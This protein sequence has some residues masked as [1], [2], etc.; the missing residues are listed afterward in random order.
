MKAYLGKNIYGLSKST[1]KYIEN[2]DR[3]INIEDV[4]KGINFED[5]NIEK[6]NA[7][8]VDNTYLFVD[9]FKNGFNF[10]EGLMK[11]DVVSEY[12][13]FRTGCLGEKNKM[14]NGLNKKEK[15]YF[16]LNR[17]K[18]VEISNFMKYIEKNFPLLIMFVNKNRYNRFTDKEILDLQDYVRLKE[19]EIER[20]I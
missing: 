10:N 16:D 9:F 18:I 15:L 5:I 6:I 20:N 17:H 2:D 11:K 4:Y 7:I 8:L 12:K 14:I 1:L 19:R 13:I 3:F